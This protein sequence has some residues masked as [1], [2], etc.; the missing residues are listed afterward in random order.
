[1]AGAICTAHPAIIGNNAVRAPRYVPRS[2]DHQPSGGGSSAAVRVCH[3]TPAA[4]PKRSSPGT[5]AFRIVCWNEADR[6]G[7]VRETDSSLTHGGSAGVGGIRS[8]MLLKYS[9]NAK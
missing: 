1:M 7:Q 2:T 8:H 5:Q 6:V 4:I 3:A 9:A